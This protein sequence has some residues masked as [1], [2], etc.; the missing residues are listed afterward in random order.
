MRK[1][2]LFLILS[3]TVLLGSTSVFAIPGLF[4]TCNTSLCNGSAARCNEVCRL[5]SGQLSMCLNFL[6]DY[7]GDGVPNSTDNCSCNPNANQANCDGDSRGDVCDPIDN[8]WQLTLD[9]SQVC[10]VDVDN[11]TF[12]ETIE[13]YVGDVYQ[14]SCTGATCI[15]KVLKDDFNCPGPSGATVS[16]CQSNA[17]VIDCAGAWNSDQCGTP[18][19]TF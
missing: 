10:E 6:S 12:W 2:R 16:C 14:S 5:P 9:S 19:C 15:K 3:V 13:L 1:V 11:H 4:P 7:D 8:S 17:S 18:R